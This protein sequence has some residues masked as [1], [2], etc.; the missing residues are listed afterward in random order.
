METS[1]NLTDHPLFFHVPSERL[2]YL[3]AGPCHCVFTITAAALLTMEAV[4]RHGPVAGQT[5]HPFGQATAVA[6]LAED[7]TRRGLAEATA[8]TSEALES[9][10]AD[11]GDVLMP[12]ALESMMTL[13]AD[14]CDA[15]AERLH[16]GE[17]RSTAL[18][19]TWGSAPCEVTAP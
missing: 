11:F 10:C 2:L 4:V 6:S 12:G 7:G 18:A 1:A 5:T 17:A 14:F 19:T 9:L 13:W 16:D 15:V 8:M 3:A